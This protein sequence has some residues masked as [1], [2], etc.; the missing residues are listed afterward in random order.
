MENLKSIEF[1]NVLYP[2][3]VLR[4]TIAP[5]I[6][7]FSLITAGYMVDEALLH[8]TGR[9][10]LVEHCVGNCD[11]ALHTFPALLS[12]TPNLATL[13]IDT[14]EGVV[15]EMLRFLALKAVDSL[16]CRTLQHIDVSWCRDL[17][18]SSLC[19]FVKTPIRI[20]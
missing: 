11:L 14:I 6:T 3:H 5:S 2:L 16:P 17:T 1:S 13:R 9:T 12:S 15:N 4:G 20:Y 19:A 10:S 18:T 8:I 7:H